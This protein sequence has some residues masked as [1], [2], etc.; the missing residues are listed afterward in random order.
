MLKVGQE[1]ER[2]GFEF[3][4][5]CIKYIGTKMEM[6]NIIYLFETYKNILLILYS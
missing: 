2:F 1:V 6:F 3:E 5:L 4:H